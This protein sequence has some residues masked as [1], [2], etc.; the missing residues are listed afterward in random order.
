MRS[1]TL[2][3]NA[4]INLAL[5]VLGKRSDGYHELRMIMQSVSIHDVIRLEKAESGITFQCGGGA[6]TDESNLAVKAAR[7]L[8]EESGTK[9]GVKITLEKHIPSMAGMAGGS[10]DCA[11][12]LIGADML[13]DLKTPRKK[14]LKMACSLGADVP[15][16]TLGGTKICEGIG[17]KMIE[18]PNM[19]RC[20]IVVVKPSVSV[21]TP[22]AFAKYDSITSPKKGDF[23]GMVS[24]FE[25]GDLGGIGSLLFNALEY[26]ADLPQIKQA[27]EDLMKCGAQGALM[28][29]SGSAVYGIFESGEAA[30]KCAETLKEL[31][32]FCEVCAP[33]NCGCE[34]KE[35][36]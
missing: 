34:V 35:C 12:A 10:A 9:G 3:A 11:A 14:M 1:V 29:G 5:D 23:N 18:L 4:K 19:P 2:F 25:R 32:P 7:L 13:F 8:L 26:A 36:E 24:A 22:E 17:E 30:E 20:A 16:C 27:K 6:P 28:T 31:Y 21:S 15:F 33:V